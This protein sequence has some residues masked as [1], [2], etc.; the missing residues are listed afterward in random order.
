[1]TE[2]TQA[3]EIDT[4]GLPGSVR[5]RIALTHGA[6]IW[7]RLW[8]AVLPAVLV[9]CAFVAVV[10][11]DVLPALSGVAH[12]VVLALF[13]VA[14][15]GAVVWG[16]ARLRWPSHAT[17][18]RRLE[19]SGGSHRPLTAW[20]DQPAL[21]GTDVASRALW[22]AH[23]DRAR[24]AMARLRVPLPRPQ[25]ARRDPFA[26]RAI[27]VLGLVVACV[28]GLGSAEDRVARALNPSFA[29]EVAAMP[30]RVDV[31]ISP[32]AYT[33]LAPIALTAD[34]TEPVSVPADSEVL[35]QVHG[36][37]VPPSIAFAGT[38]AAPEKIGEQ[39]Y[40]ATFRLTEDGTIAIGDGAQTLAG[41]DVVVL[42]DRPPEAAFA[43]EPS[44]TERHALRVDV[45]ALDDYG[46]AE[47][48]LQI[49]LDE[50][51]FDAAADPET[52]MDLPLPLPSRAPAELET[53]RYH[54]LTPH[55][56][57]GVPVRMRLRA[58]DALG[59]VGFSDVV[60]MILPER[61]F[62]HPVARAIIEQRKILVIA[63]DERDLVAENLDAIADQPD[64]FSN[65]LTV[66][67]ALK[68]AR[69]R[70]RLA[71]AGDVDSVQQILWDTALYLEDGGLALAEQELRRL[72]EELADALR[73]G[74][75]EEEIQ[76]LIE[77]LRQAMENYMQELAENMPLMSPE[78][79]NQLQLQMPDDPNQ[80]ITNQDLME[81]LE[82]LR[83]LTEMGATEE[84]QQL[85]SELQ[86]MLENM[87]PMPFQMQ[88]Q[89]SEQMEMLNN[90]NDVVREQRELLDET[91]R[92][93][94]NA[95]GMTPM[96]GTPQSEDGTQE[97]RSSDELE[98]AQRDLRGQLGEV[99]REFGDMVGEIPD[100]L[101]LAEREMRRA[102]Q[103]LEGDMPG[104][105]TVAQQQALEHLQ[106]GMNEAA[107]MMAE[108]GM[109]QLVPNGQPYRFGQ[110][111]QRPAQ[112]DP[113]GRAA[114]EDRGLDTGDVDLP[115]EEEMKKAREILE[116]LQRRAGEAFRDRE[117]LD[118]IE[119][120]LRRF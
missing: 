72:Q 24:M 58:V 89:P 120:L 1:M 59:Q 53:T 43:E 111:E 10:L 50:A 104:E 82:Q 87:Q 55:I 12:I 57:A 108:M 71:D 69:S 102:E 4:S 47:L 97:P 62:T 54:D 110:G 60:S 36:V 18:T 85:L 113:L 112:R 39:S 119:R 105:A 9:L 35:A 32:P 116:E 23:R 117:E 88:Q 75:S 21:S 81:M 27:A 63:P 74:A 115:T 114:P 77:E 6:L 118:Y 5:R 64:D 92:N 33:R 80:T 93:A 3:S 28:V 34:Q 52:R 42:A 41:W 13:G 26:I 100:N 37:A 19:A 101:G 67:L 16:L 96:P 65:D 66:Y 95:P 79:L 22:S 20:L 38:A 56:W 45:H 14:F 11:L 31:W 17:A 84:A 70:L 30:V 83:E 98:Q 106:E 29:P 44:E 61:E 15:L 73:D 99:M 48:T 76:R 94:Q 91:Y 46:L 8:P 107:Q 86:N 2:R 7:E 25:I 90:L 78:D 51:M 49:V 109:L 103:L 68:T 40:S